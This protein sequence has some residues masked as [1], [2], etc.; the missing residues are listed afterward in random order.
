MFIRE[1]KI[2][3][4][5]FAKNNKSATKGLSTHSFGVSFDISSIQSSGYCEEALVAL[6]KALT[7]MQ[8]KKQ[9]LIC[10]ENGCYHITVVK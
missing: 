1:T 7:K 2:N 8:E 3:K 6:S 10:P 5:F 4:K 9:L